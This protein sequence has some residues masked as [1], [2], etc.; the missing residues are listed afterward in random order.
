MHMTMSPLFIPMKPRA[1]TI[2]GIDPG[3]ARFGWAIVTMETSPQLVAAGCFTTPANKPVSQRLA[4]LAIK[5]RQVIHEYQPSMMALEEL[6]FSKNVS[7]AMAV[8][9]ARGVA[10]LVAA[11]NRLSTKEFG[12]TTVKSALT[13]YGR[14]DKRQVQSMVMHLLG[15]TKKPRYDDTTDAMAV[16][17]CGSQARLAL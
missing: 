6:F 17:I 8:G 2:L 12:P 11:E 1:K 9:Q 3:L 16:A 13:G 14:A 4:L 10:L 5:L 7:T 15:I